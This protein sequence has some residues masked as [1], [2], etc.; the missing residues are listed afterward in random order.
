MYCI[1]FDWNLSKLFFFDVFIIKVTA[2]QQYHSQLTSKFILTIIILLNTYD[3]ID[4]IGNYQLNL[5]TGLQ[6]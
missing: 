5:S 6:K 2:S 4:Y 3:K 1:L